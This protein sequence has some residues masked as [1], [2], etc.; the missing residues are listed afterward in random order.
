VDR[1]K[2]ELQDMKRAPWIRLLCIETNDNQESQLRESGDFRTMSI[3]ASDYEQ[4][5][6][7]PDAYNE[8]ILLTQWVDKQTLEKLPGKQVA[9][10][11]GNIRMVGRLSFFYEDNYNNIKHAIQERVDDL[12][13]LTV[14]EAME[15]RGTLPDGSNP[16]VAFGAN[17][18]VRV[19]VVGT[20]CGGTCSGLAADF[21]FFLRTICNEEERLI[22]MYTL[23]RT[24]LSS[25]LE[26]NANR[27]KRN[28]Y[29]ALLELNHYHLAGRKNEGKI[30]FPD[31]IIADTSLFP[32]DIPFLA[33]PRMVGAEGEPRDE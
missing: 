4:I 23:P 11:A 1:V 3:S 9:T 17:G 28:A 16:A 25:A 5:L 20:L 27:Y 22:A 7:N 15:K 12:R 19:I 13:R 29:H 21:G 18:N 8:K 26:P 6:S 33:V 24:D 30:R 31:G 32:Y 14:P 10:G 2:W